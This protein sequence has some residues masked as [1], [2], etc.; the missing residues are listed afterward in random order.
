MTEANPAVQERRHS[1]R[2]SI[3]G[4]EAAVQTK[5]LMLFRD[6]H[7]CLVS[8]I[9]ERGIGLISSGLE[10]EQ[11]QDIRLV[12]RDNRFEHRV[13]GKVVFRN[14]LE[15]FDWYGVCFEGLPDKLVERINGWSR[16]A[17][18]RRE[19]LRRKK[20]LKANSGSEEYTRY[21]EQRH[22]SRY[23]VPLVRAAI[24]NWAGDA[25]G[26]HC[27]EAMVTDISRSGLYLMMMEHNALSQRVHLEL[28]DGKESIKLIGQVRHINKQNVH[29]G[30]GIEYLHQPPGFERFF[31]KYCGQPV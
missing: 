24:R 5:K 6:Y 14:T 28:G 7:Q 10:L 26:E 21:G 31:N 2:I 13:E 20:Q 22:E 12:I 29:L 1:P 4:L 27:A 3:R 15:E 17:I 19:M 25:P 18:M 8:D 30:Y 9:S 23:P 11:D 16:V